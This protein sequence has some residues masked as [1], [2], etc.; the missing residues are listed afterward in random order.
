[1]LRWAASSSSNSVVLPCCWWRRLRAVP[2]CGGRRQVGTLLGVAEPPCCDQKEGIGVHRVSGTGSLRWPRHVHNHLGLRRARPRA[3]NEQAG[4]LH[5]PNAIANRILQQEKLGSLLAAEMMRG[6]QKETSNDIPK[7]ARKKE[8]QTAVCRKY[9]T[10]LS[11]LIPFYCPCCTEACEMY[12]WFINTAVHQLSS[13]IL[14]SGSPK[15][16]CGSFWG[17]FFSAASEFCPISFLVPLGSAMLARFYFDKC[18]NTFMPNEA[19]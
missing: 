14:G 11:I 10:S 12:A 5:V 8:R 4:D 18:L 9:L 13:F 16:V 15:H 6:R 19:R 2:C 3:G 17:C 1:M 7:S